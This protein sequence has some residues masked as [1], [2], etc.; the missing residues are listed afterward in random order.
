[1]IAAIDKPKVRKPALDGIVEH[2]ED[3]LV[4]LSPA[5][6]HHHRRVLYVNSYGGRTILDKIKQGM[7]PRHHLWGCFELVKKGYEVA[8]AE[9]LPDFYLYRNPF[10]HDFR[11]LRI[12][13]SWLG[14]DGIVY[15]GHNVLYWLPFLRALGAVRCHIVSLLFAREPLDFGRAHRG[16]IALTAAGAEHARKLAPNAKVG[17]L[18]W[19]ADLKAFPRLSYRPDWFLSCGITQRDHATLSAA[20]ARSRSSVRLIVPELPENISWPENV[21]IVTSRNGGEAVAYADLLLD[22]YAR[23]AASLI[24][25]KYDPVE[26]TAVG[27]TNLIEAMAMSRPV[28]VTRTGALPTEI[29]V[30]RSG[31]GV[32]VPPRD[33][34]ALAEAIDALADDRARARAMGEQG[35]RLCESHYNIERYA[36]ELHEFFTSL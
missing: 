4:V 22:Q 15:C 24:I 30:E 31:C 36:D 21:S 6:G 1:M 27:M 3:G 2:A 8:L 34:G 35:R 19:G 7:L 13:C 25:L 28:I 10:P 23:C 5:D 29:D 18:G 14:R 9:P 12:V 16:V 11:L 17:H 20:A 26:Y 32:F 33:P